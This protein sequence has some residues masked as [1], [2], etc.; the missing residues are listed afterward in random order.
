MDMPTLHPGGTILLSAGPRAG[1]SALLGRW[2]QESTQPTLLLTL[3]VEDRVPEFLRHR[4]LLAWPEVREPYEALTRSGLSP[5]WGARLAIA[6]AEA[7]PTTCLLVDDLHLLEDSEALPEL[8]A[9]LR[10][11]PRTGALAVASRHRLPSLQRPGCHS[12]EAD[13]PHWHEAPHPDDLITL[14]DPLRAEALALTLTETAP[15]SPEGLELVRRN[16]AHLTPDDTVQLRRPWLS[17]AHVLIQQSQPDGLWPQ[18]ER[19]L[20]AHATR[21]LRTARKPS[22]AD[23]LQRIPTAVRAAQPYLLQLEGDTHCATGQYLQA[24]GCY[25]QALALR[26]AAKGP[27]A[28]LLIRLA[29][30]ATATEDLDALQVLLARLEALPALEPTQ[31]AQTLHLKGLSHWFEGRQDQAEE[32]WREILGVPAAGERAVYYEQFRALRNL[33]SLSVNQYRQADA[34]RYADQMLRLATTHGFQVD[35]LRAHQAKFDALALDENAP[36]RFEQLVSLPLDAFIGLSTENFLCY[37]LGLS[38][39]AYQHQDHALAARLCRY[40]LGH[41]QA[42][43]NLEH[44]HAAY[45]GLMNALSRIGRFEEAAATRDELLR[46]QPVAK[47]AGSLARQWALALHRQGRDAEAVEHLQRHLNT[48]LSEHDTTFG[49]LVLLGIEA[50]AGDANAPAAIDALLAT[51]HGQRLRKSESLV[52]EELG[53][54]EPR[55]VL[56]IRGF[57]DLGA[58]RG[59]AQ[60]A[61]WPRKKALALLAH[62]VLHPEG[63]SSESLAEWLFNDPEA[64]EPLHTTVYGMRQSLKAIGLGDILESTR[65]LYR[66]KQDQVA[67]CDLYA[68]E[69]LYENARALEALGQ[70]GMAV[71]FDELALQVGNAPLF[72][73]LPDDFEAARERHQERLRVSRSAAQAHA[74]FR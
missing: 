16:L 48:P 54:A 50:K 6:L 12:L 33:Q 26:E 22:L 25:R 36:P 29:K 70:K 14:P 8:L 39:N 7:T 20:S 3:S 74:S 57:G 42:H 15:P 65:G 56:R 31:H 17:P 68:F 51:P 44:M 47:Y 10:H 41:A 28:D 30:V 27:T 67:F 37:L 19:R 18:V 43:D 1:K 21:L 49:R 23:L 24:L 9:L 52:L 59:A 58:Y 35:L 46:L 13:A 55:P 4:L 73:N 69:A 40:H 11:F 63:C 5:S 66:L 32:R 60:A 2:Q 38:G 71:V 61:R 45:L 34:L 53:L 62:L 72:D 64:L